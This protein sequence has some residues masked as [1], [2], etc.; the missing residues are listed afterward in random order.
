M[1]KLV[2]SSNVTINYCK[3]GYLGGVLMT[4]MEKLY[5]ERNKRMEIAQR[6]GVPDRVPVYSLVDNWAFSYAGYSIEEI[7]ENDEKHFT[8][9]YEM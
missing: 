9:L 3:N 7:F 2:K 4:E 6:G 1:N 8:L 5:Q